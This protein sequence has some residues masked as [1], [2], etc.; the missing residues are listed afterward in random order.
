M[1]DPSD[2]HQPRETVCQ[3]NLSADRATGRK[4]SNFVRFP[5]PSRTEGPMGSPGIAPFP[6]KII[7]H[8]PFQSIITS[9]AKLNAPIS[10]N[11]AIVFK[12]AYCAKV[13]CDHPLNLTTSSTPATCDNIPRAKTAFPTRVD[14]FADQSK[15]CT[16]PSNVNLIA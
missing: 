11:N 9:I 8:R 6:D 2:I 12:Y 4:R 16:S 14:T 1:L 3:L 7:S 15:I 13:S 5:E 10:Y